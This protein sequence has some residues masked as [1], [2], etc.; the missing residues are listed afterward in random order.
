MD[1]NPH[2]VHGYQCVVPEVSRVAA[3]PGQN[4]QCAAQGIGQRGLRGWVMPSGE[5]KAAETRP[6]RRLHHSALYH[7]PGVMTS[8][9]QV[10]RCRFL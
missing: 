10:G 2:W 9:T 6:R 1:E 7:E 4:G 5:G 3:A 8:R